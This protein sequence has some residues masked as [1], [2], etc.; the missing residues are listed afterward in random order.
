MTNQNYNRVLA[1]LRKL[2]FGAAAASAALFVCNGIAGVDFGS[3]GGSVYAQEY[4]YDESVDDLEEFVS[5][6]VANTPLRTGDDADAS[7]DSVNANVDVSSGANLSGS[8]V[9]F[10]LVGPDASS[11]VTASDDITISGSAHAYV[12]LLDESSETAGAIA[13]SANLTLSE[14]KKI[15]IGALESESA[16][17]LTVVGQGESGSSVQ[18][19]DKANLVVG[20]KGLLEI[21]GAAAGTVAISSQGQLFNL[22]QSDATAT[23]GVS[24]KSNGIL[25]VGSQNSL[26]SG[27]ALDG[28]GN[29][30]NLGRVTIYNESGDDNLAYIGVYTDSS[31]AALNATG[32]LFMNGGGEE[33]GAIKINGILSAEEWASLNDAT[34]A[35]TASVTISGLATLGG[36]SDGASL[37]IEGASGQTSPNVRLGGLKAYTAEDG[38]SSGGALSLSQNAVALITGLETKMNAAGS[39]GTGGL[40]DVWLGDSADINGT[41]AASSQ[42]NYTSNLND[43]GIRWEGESEIG[44]TGKLYAKNLT[45]S[46]GSETTGGKTALKNA[47]SLVV[48]GELTVNLEDSAS[49]FELTNTAASSASSVISSWKVGAGQTLTNGIADDATNAAAL[50]VNTLQLT[51]GTAHT[52]GGSTLSVGNLTIDADSNSGANAALRSAGSS[53]ITVR[54]FT[55]A[56]GLA[57]LESNAGAG[58]LTSASASSVYT[59]GKADQADSEFAQLQLVGSDATFKS[60]ALNLAG[61]GVL[62]QENGHTLNFSDIALFN[63]SQRASGYSISASKLVFS[64]TSSFTG[65]KTVKA[66]SM[67]FQNGTTLN[68]GLNDDLT[69]VEN[70][71]LNLENGSSLNVEFGSDGTT[72]GKVVLSGEGAA[73]LAEGS[74]VKAAN[75]SSLADGVYR[76]TV[77]QTESNGNAFNGSVEE[78]P[79]YTLS[80]IVS[81]DGKSLDLELNIT[82]DV[83]SYARNGN[84]KAV[85][86]YFNE[87]RRAGDVSES[88]RDKM[89]DFFELTDHDAISSSLQ[90]LGAV[91]RANSLTLAMNSPWRQAF[92]QAGMARRRDLSNSALHSYDMYSTYRG[93]TF[94]PQYGYSPYQGDAG[95]NFFGPTGEV[96]AWASANYRGESIRSDGISEKF[97]VT[98]VGMNVGYDARSNNAVAG[99]V[100]GYSQPKLYSND[101]RVH[102]SNF[103]L[104]F[105]GG[106][107]VWEFLDAKV[108]VGGGLQDYTSKRT[109]TIGSESSFH[110][111]TF[112]GQSLAAAFQLSHPFHYSEYSVL[113]PV[114]QIDMQ[115]SWQDDSTE[116]GEGVALAYK[117]ADYNQT[118]VRGGLESELNSPFLLFNAHALYGYRISGDDAPESEFQFTGVNSPS[119]ARVSGVKQ[120]DSV[121]DAGVSAQGYLDCER[122][123]IISG[124]YDFVTSDKSTSHL[125]TVATSYTF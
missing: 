87:S 29:F 106:S 122:R 93:Q 49:S 88:L 58:G 112:D 42:T 43:L 53:K 121:I 19:G 8:A 62:I 100:F 72:T 25:T 65:G 64:G 11:T 119:F 30:S 60:G 78:K 111:A 9:T 74:V 59:V 85:A 104:G 80:T 68:L 15:I 39:V 46:L 98:D 89:D 96:N 54:N 44:G 118:F 18:I 108:Y 6:R 75:V 47:G 114:F 57:V 107:S 63:N 45:L 50:T 41:L 110:R 123:W 115:Q 116:S 101:T 5:I 67:T 97:G 61:Q 14:E 3:N 52:Y 55:L 82:R 76:G 94:D 27:S 117:K 66:D 10:G 69:L 13:G 83:E 16:G 73:T 56:R 90:S 28:D 105:Y 79:F 124:G 21:G 77:I 1:T 26:V 32:K 92:E 95:V 4:V 31:T 2:I 17:V 109:A 86:K 37:T 71:S 35:S 20:N 12:A 24:V 84:Q 125:G 34:F 91:Q 23:R 7:A 120:G 70:G 99:F 38:D 22:G 36:T 33:G 81:E 113:R 40:Y 103:Q 48:R 51:G 102:A